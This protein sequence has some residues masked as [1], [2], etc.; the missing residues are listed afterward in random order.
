M[1]RRTSNK[2]K[3][4]ALVVYDPIRAANWRVEQRRKTA[5][6]SA[7]VDGLTAMQ[8]QENLRRIWDVSE[9]HEKSVKLLLTV[10]GCR[11]LMDAARRDLGRELS[12]QRANEYY[13]FRARLERLY[14][15]A[16]NARDMPIALAVLKEQIA[17]SER[18]HGLVTIEDA[19]ASEP[20]PGA[21]K[22]FRSAVRRLEDAIGECNSKRAANAG[23]A[24]K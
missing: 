14:N 1:A 2:K 24:K 9:G 21:S 4:T 8:L 6:S 10:S 17:L 16:M 22:A 20:I 18:S 3:S 7:V 19:K 23:R 13:Q 5:A 11:K 12:K 15:L